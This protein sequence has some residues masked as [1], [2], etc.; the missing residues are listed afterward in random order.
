LSPPFALPSTARPLLAAEIG[1]NHGGRL[2]LAAEL[3]KSAAKAGAGAVK[4]QAYRTETFLHRDS[5]FFAELLAEELSFESLGRLVEL[6]HSLG[7][8]AGLTVFDAEGLNLARAS[9][10]DYVKIS[11]G[12]LTHRRL[13]RAAAESGLPM[14]L[15]TGAASHGEVEA[16]LSLCA[17]CALLQCCALYPAPPELVH[18]AV[19]DRWLRQGRPAG[20]SDHTLG[21]QVALAALELGAVMVE[22]HFTVDRRLPGGDNAMSATPEEFRLLAVQIQLQTKLRRLA[23]AQARPDRPDRPDL[24][25]RPDLADLAEPAD[26]ADLGY[27]A[28]RQPWWGVPE[29]RRQP[30]EAPALIRRAAVAARPLAAGEPLTEEAVVFLRPPAAAAL[31][32]AD[33]PLADLILTRPVAAGRLVTLEDLSARDG[34]TPAFGPADASPEASAAAWPTVGRA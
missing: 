26:Q 10:A 21:P 6:A 23:E 33:R 34:R 3:V 16:A 14:A 1:G 5:P 30:G 17:P 4:F 9:R 19:L 11:S 12:D 27:P 18:L 32:G 7:L 24:T 31:L 29:K 20:L 8:A 15:S 25:D 28:S 13:I 2:E 22:K